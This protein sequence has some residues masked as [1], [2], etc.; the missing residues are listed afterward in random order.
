MHLAI[1]CEVIKRWDRCKTENSPLNRKV[2]L[3]CQVKPASGSWPIL[4]QLPLESDEVHIED[5]PSANAEPSDGEEMTW[6][7]PGQSRAASLAPPM[8]SPS[9]SRAHVWGGQG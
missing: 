3:L 9:S 1:T 5:K 4:V 7:S 8:G 2:R 6:G